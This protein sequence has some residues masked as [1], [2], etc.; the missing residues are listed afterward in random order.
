[1]FEIEPRSNLG[2]LIMAVL[3]GLLSL[4]ASHYRKLD[5]QTVDTMLSDLTAPT[6]TETQPVSLL[7][8]NPELKALKDKLPQIDARLSA[9]FENWQLQHQNR[10]NP[11]LLAAVADVKP[12]A[13][14]LQPILKA[15]SSDE[16]LRV[17][18]LLFM[19]IQLQPGT[20]DQAFEQLCQHLES[21]PDEKTRSMAGVLHYLKRH[22]LK[23]PVPSRL[24]PALGEFSREFKDAGCG[25]KLYAIVADS[26]RT[27]GYYDFAQ[28][29]L[30]H[31]I[32]LYSGTPGVSRLVNQMI[33]Q[34]QNL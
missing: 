32:D 34:Q 18:R 33:D 26:L 9:A 27:H 20:C 14:Q 6:T 1:M 30:R 16:Q 4:A 25:V 19:S 5:I 23:Q 29:V 31:G 21:L 15:F 7:G 11:E 3:V 12:F 28:Q 24:L 17:L 2:P 10:N 8:M 22:D 13:E